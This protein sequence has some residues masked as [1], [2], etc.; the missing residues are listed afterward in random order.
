[1]RN[2]SVLDVQEISGGTVSDNAVVLA[3]SS[4]MAMAVGF[5]SAFCYSC[6]KGEGLVSGFLMSTLGLGPALVLGT[7]IGTG[8]I[9]YKWNTQES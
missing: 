2:L 4:Y 6:Y 5:A 1:M 9:V 7:V 8:V 3:T